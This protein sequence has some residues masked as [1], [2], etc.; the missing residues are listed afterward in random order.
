MTNFELIEGAKKL[1]G[2]D[3]DVQVDTFAGWKAKGYCVNKGEHASFKTKIWKPCKVID[4]LTKE[5]KK[6]LLFVNAA[7]FTIN[8]VARQKNLEDLIDG[9]YSFKE[10]N[11]IMKTE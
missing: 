1:A 4:E 10:A 3:E 2:I 9:G 6:E 11:K 8:Q 5:E 7:F